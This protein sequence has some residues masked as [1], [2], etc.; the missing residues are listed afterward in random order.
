MD[1][2]RDCNTLMCG[3]GGGGG[4]VGEHTYSEAGRN[5]GDGE[6]RSKLKLTGCWLMMC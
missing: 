4:G 2:H 5:I 3:A 1:M 6:I